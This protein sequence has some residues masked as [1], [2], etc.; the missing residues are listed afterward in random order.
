MMTT[1]EQKRVALVTGA[2]SGIGLAIAR[3]LVSDGWTVLFAD[4]DFAAAGS[5]C[6]E[7]GGA[8]TGSRPLTLDV[9]RREEWADAV[10]DLRDREA[11]LD[12]LVNNAGITRDRTVEKLTDL[13]WHQVIDVHLTG[14]WLGCQAALP[15]LRESGGAIVNLSSEGRHGSFGQANYSAAKAGVVGLTRTIALEQARHGVR[16]NAVAPGPVDTPMLAGVPEDVVNGWLEQIPLRR[17]AQPAEIAAVVA[18]LGSEQSS[19]ITGQVIAVDGG[20][21]HP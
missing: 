8:G 4:R 11:R 20:S 1:R 19:Y 2:G 15:L 5:A 3:R 9:S 7:A 16:A 18:F 21:S 12:L 13:D 14:T 10:Q 17:L 6:S